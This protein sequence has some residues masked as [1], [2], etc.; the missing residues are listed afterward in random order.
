[1]TIDDDV[2]GRE[3]RYGSS[4]YR[5]ALQRPD[6][7]ALTQA[8]GTK[9]GE[10]LRPL[11]QR[12]ILEEDG[13]L[14][15][16]SDGLSDNGWVEHSW[17]EYAVPVLQGTLSLEDAVQAWIELANQKNAHDNTSVVLTYCRVFPKDIVPITP[18][19]PPA[20]IIEVEQEEQ[21]PQSKL[22]LSSQALLQLDLSELPAHITTKTPAK[23][24]G[25]RKW[26]I[27]LGGLLA[28]LVG[29]TSLGL[30]ALWRLSPQ[31][32]QQVCQRYPERLQQV[33]PP[34]GS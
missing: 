3:V 6:A 30:F 34:P 11:I 26:W 15:L 2:A 17:R 1:M 9:E 20:E 10:L 23:P 12:F 25:R 16:C 18:A 22:A 33:C 5:K 27:L 21:E 4:M 7:T 29:G 19:L 8:L 24:Q 14:L 32:F 13:I 31:T 28:L